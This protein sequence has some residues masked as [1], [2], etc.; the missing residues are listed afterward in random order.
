MP[1]VSAL[2]DPAQKGFLSATNGQCHTEDLNEF[3]YRAV[4]ENV[5]KY[6]FLLDTAKA[7]DSIDHT[8]ILKVLD[9]AAFPDWLL[10]FVRC[11]LYD[12]KALLWTGRSQEIFLKNPKRGR[13][14]S[15][16]LESY[17]ETAP[18]SDFVQARKRIWCP[19]RPA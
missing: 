17:Q 8:W 3:F 10:R 14:K 13:E 5:Q 1:A 11:S 9:K 16:I 18:D 2:L 6:V 4:G 12:V 15:R 7:F 19:F